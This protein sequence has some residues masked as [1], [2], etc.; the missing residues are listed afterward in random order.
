MDFEKT[1]IG[2]KEYIKVGI[3]GDVYTFTATMDTG[4]AG[5]VPTLGIELLENLKTKIKATIQNKEYIFEKKGEASPMVGNVQHHRPI[6]LFDFLEIKG[7]R[8]NNV[9]FAITDERK[10]STQ[11][12]I[13]RDTLRNMNFIIDPS[14]EFTK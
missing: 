8:I 14:I 12:L 1:T 2:Y 4:N 11:A 10:K 9:Y 6:V 5:V 7:K 13:N 3:N